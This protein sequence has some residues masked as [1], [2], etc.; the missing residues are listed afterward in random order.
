M[1][2]GSKSKSKR[3]ERERERLC[4]C[5][6]ARNTEPCDSLSFVLKSR[7]FSL[8]LTCYIL[9]YILSTATSD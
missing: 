8:A 9:V 7:P 4:V 5:K 6:K 1:E 2:I 3:G